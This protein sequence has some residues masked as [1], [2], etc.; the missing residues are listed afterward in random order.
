MDIE[1][2]KKLYDDGNFEEIHV[3]EL[4]REIE[5]QRY[6]IDNPIQMKLFYCTCR[7]DNGSFIKHI[8]AQDEEIAKRRFITEATKTG[9]YV[10]SFKVKEIKYVDSCKV[11]MVKRVKVNDIL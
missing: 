2:M 6:I 7:A 8:A 5:R 1:M 9:K 11:E 4:I 10:G 3:L